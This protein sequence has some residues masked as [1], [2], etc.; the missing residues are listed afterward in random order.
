MTERRLTATCRV[1]LNEQFTLVGARTI[2]P[3]LHRLG[4]SHLYASPILAARPGSTHGYD[5]ADPTNVSPALG[6][7][8]ARQ[9]LVRELHTHG[10][11]MVLDIVPNHMGTGPANPFWEDVLA[12]GEA[13]AYAGWFDVDWD[14]PRPA[15]RHRILLPVLGDAF[16]DVVARGELGVAWQDGRIRMNYFDQS[17]PLDPG[18]LPAVLDF[19]LGPKDRRGGDHSLDELAAIADSL[20]ELPPRED[21][22][23]SERRRDASRTALD[24]LAA[25]VAG[26]AGAR[27]WME[28]G[29]RDFC[30]GELGTRRIQ[31]LLD[32]QAYHLV[33][34]RQAARDIN[35]RRFFDVTELIAL[36]VERP[37]VFAATHQLV[38]GWVEDGTLDGLRIDHVDGLYAPR[39][40][41]DRL[42]SEV[43][44]RRSGDSAYPIFVE[45]I[46]SPGERLRP[47]WPVQGT[48]GYEFLNDL[49]AIFI[50]PDG[51]ATIE[52]AYHSLVNEGEPPLPFAE[53]AIRGKLEILRGSLQADIRR[54]VR[55][56]VGDGDDT[57]ESG[58]TRWELRVALVELIASLPVYRTYVE[59]GR[60]ADTVDR[61]VLARA[62][63]RA[64][65]RAAATPHTLDRLVQIVRDATPDADAP[66][67]E[68]ARRDRFVARF[69]QTSGPATAKGVEDT[70][71]YRFVPLVSRNEVGGEPDRPLANAVGVLHRGAVERV[72]QWPQ[73]LLATNTHDTKRSADVR[74]RLD[75][76]SEIPDRWI[77][78]ARTWLRDGERR[79]TQVRGS[80]VPDA[81][82]EYLML[83]TL[84]GLWPFPAGDAG[85]D[86]PTLSALGERVGEYML[87]AA[88]E[89]KTHTS[90]T[91]S[92]E[93]YERALA[94]YREA[95]LADEHTVRH[96]TALVHEVAY[97]G[98]W[99]SLAR[100][101]VHL[102]SPGTPDLYQGDECWNFALVDP[103]NRRPVDWPLR[104]RLL[105]ALDSAWERGETS[106]RALVADLVSNP[107]DD[108]IKLHLTTRVLRARREH[109]DRFAGS[110]APL[111]AEG[112]ASAHVVAFARHGAYGS[113][114]A[115]A[116]RLVRTLAGT[117]PPIGALWGDTRITLPTPLSAQSWR[118]VITGESVSLDRGALSLSVVLADFPVA[119]LLSE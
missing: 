28:D 94:D 1:Q 68:P 106:R 4:V 82:A 73:A 19:V 93:A 83:Q 70:A 52:R 15:L 27:R 91:Q 51:Y 3:Y 40:Y 87:K 6:G 67:Q 118:D 95:A 108:R 62:A 89:A 23:Q 116:P 101:L 69:Q 61:A 2:V 72:T 77:A 65:A 99:T 37:D 47:E 107:A 35:Y 54:L 32:E 24:R 84:V 22:D 75:V 104:D 44:R 53:E 100:V 41:L 71:L 81:N 21:R 33:G 30:A 63:Q 102:S 103:D 10:M 55:L 74:A 12:H 11:G 45:K 115:I 105:A 16:E 13:S 18:T 49:E 29:L 50:H 64:R 85:P 39:A 56:L 9:A 92:D 78:D 96:V 36:R 86:A 112:A 31:S 59:A 117:R 114:L 60:E 57:T 25:L 38:L 14:I 110:Y 79:R 58:G 8:P 113:A 34:W 46:L 98:A 17:F 111:S 90:W 80:Q 7:E 109:A 5:V 42:R 119:L 26:D 48:T 43:A 97:P 66:A 20:R 88:R 76:L